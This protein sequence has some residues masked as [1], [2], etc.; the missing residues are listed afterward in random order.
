MA[1]AGW[2][3]VGPVPGCGGLPPAPLNPTHARTSKQT[4]PLTLAHANKPFTLEQGD[5]L[6]GPPSCSSARVLRCG[7]RTCGEACARYRPSSRASASIGTGLTPARICIGP[8]LTPARIC[9]GLLGRLCRGAWGPWQGRVGARS[10]AHLMPHAAPS[11]VGHA[12]LSRLHAQMTWRAM[13]AEVGKGRARAVGVSNYSL[14]QARARARVCLRA[15]TAVCRG[16][17]RGGVCAIP[18]WLRS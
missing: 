4:I 11:A 3:V 10:H 8:G 14:E 5:R 13:V 15:L 18:R 2:C 16:I 9:I 17:S 12:G 1:A 6:I 7:R